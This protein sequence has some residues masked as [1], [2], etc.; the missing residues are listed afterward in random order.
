MKSGKYDV[1]VIGSG[2]G[3]IYAAALLARRGY[4]V[5]F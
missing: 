1:A 4:K 5:L 2:A 3:G